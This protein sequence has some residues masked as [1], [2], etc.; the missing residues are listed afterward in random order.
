MNYWIVSSATSPMQRTIRTKQAAE[1]LMTMAGD[2]WARDIGVVIDALG[3][4][5]VT[6]AGRSMGGA[7]SGEADRIT[8]ELARI[9]G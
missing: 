2:I 6:L 1:P 5:D 9:S 7:I 4:R 8:D 3:L